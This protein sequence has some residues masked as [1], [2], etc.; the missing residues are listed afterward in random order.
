[1]R[2]KKL[3]ALIAGAIMALSLF[4]CGTSGGGPGKPVD[5]D[6][7]D[8]PPS[9]PAE[10]AADFTL[11]FWNGVPNGE[12]KLNDDGSIAIEKGAVV[13]EREYSDDEMNAFYRD[14]VEAGFNIAFPECYNTS[15]AY[16]IKILKAAKSAG[17]RQVIQDSRVTEYLVNRDNFEK[18]KNGTLTEDRAVETVRGYLQPYLQY[19]SF[20]SLMLMDEPAPNQLDLV[21]W[22]KSVINKAAPDVLFYC[23]LLPIY[24]IQSGPS[25]FTVYDEYLNN[26]FGYTGENKFL[27]YDF[28]ALIKSSST[29][30]LVKNWLRNICAVREAIEKFD[31]E[32]DTETELWTFTLSVEHGNYRALTSKADATFQAYTNMAYGAN[33]IFWF[34][35]WR[36]NPGAENGYKDGMLTIDGKRTPVYDYVKDANIELT[37]LS[38]VYKKYQWRGVLTSA[39]RD[40]SGNLYAIRDKVNNTSKDLVS[41]SSTRDALCGLF[42]NSSGNDAYLAVNFVEPS[43]SLADNAITMKIKDHTSAEVYINGE[44]TVMPIADGTLTFTLAAGQG[45]FVIPC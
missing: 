39:V 1:M 7:P 3:I 2:I 20:Y 4:G 19:E 35:Y 40:S 23:N 17:I 27:S 11:G 22:A 14:I 16:N 34:T 25:D 12:Y 42:E 8:L 15:Q 41:F 32:H 28:Y 38:E 10:Y 44:K 37:K 5:P 13:Y 33:G 24:G 18:F 26:Y 21:G 36:P 9:P 45:A 31:S 6:A 30:S 43:S 29:N